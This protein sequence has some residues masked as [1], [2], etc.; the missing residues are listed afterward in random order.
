LL[1]GKTILFESS[2]GGQVDPASGTF[3]FDSQL[4]YYYENG[5][6]KKVL[7]DVIF[8]GNLLETLKKISLVGKIIDYDNSGTCGKS[9]QWVPVSDGGP[10][11]RVSGINVS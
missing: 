5:E 10:R 3:Q 7:R 4:A 11:V 2:K 8:G 9:G 6:K 1:E